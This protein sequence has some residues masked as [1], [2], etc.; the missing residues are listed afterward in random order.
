[1]IATTV[2]TFHARREPF[3]Y[4]FDGRTGT[5]YSFEA[6]DE[7]ANK[8]Q[9]GCSLAQ[10]ELLASVDKGTRLALEVQVKK[11]KATTDGISLAAA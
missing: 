5:Y 7:D 1:M 2:V 6:I 10:H 8:V 11:V 9:I 3:P 4:D